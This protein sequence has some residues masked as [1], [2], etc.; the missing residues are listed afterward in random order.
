MSSQELV[1]EPGGRK[2]MWA[3]NSRGEH[4][5]VLCHHW[6][7]SELGPVGDCLNAATWFAPEDLIDYAA[8]D[9]HVE[10]LK[11]RKEREDIP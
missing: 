4:P 6:V 5:A 2:L 9:E 11:V 8:C 1:H 7:P 3:T 10:W